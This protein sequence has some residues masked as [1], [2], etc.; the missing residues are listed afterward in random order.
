MEEQFVPYEI[1]LQLKELGFNKQCLAH[2]SKNSLYIFY[3]HDDFYGYTVLVNFIESIPKES[4]F[5][6]DNITFECAAPLWQQ[7][8]DWLFE[9]HNIC[10]SRNMTHWM[11][12]SHFYS[13]TFKSK[14]E[15]FLKAIELLNKNINGK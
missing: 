10:I 5:K 12:M 9:H 6:Q 11:V 7:A 1:A 2:W 3:P 15:A 4:Q 8:F 13:F 14:E